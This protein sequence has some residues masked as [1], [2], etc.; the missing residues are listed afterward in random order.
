M[1]GYDEAAKNTAGP[2]RRLLQRLLPIAFYGGLLLLLALILSKNLSQLGP[3][4]VMTAIAYDSESY[5]FAIGLA[6]WIQWGC[7]KLH[8]RTRWSAAAALSLLFAGLTVFTLTADL[9]GSVKTLNE[10]F[11]ALAVLVP[12]VTLPRPLGAWPVAGSLLLAILIGVAVGV[13]PGS[14]VVALAEGMTIL[15]LTPWAFDVLDREVLDPRANVSN[16]SRLVLYCVL[17]LVPMF[18]VA[19]GVERRT[20]GGFINDVLHYLGRSQ[21]SF[22]G[23]L[24]VMVYLA[25][26]RAVQRSSDGARIPAERRALVPGIGRPEHHAER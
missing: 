5:V 14:L 18:V 21:E 23:V 20:Q 1:T 12:F 13:W 16:W 10:A 17:F 19:L 7:W 6:A 8:G 11:F 25:A 2:R 3:E 9:P 22:V 15:A 4:R 26:V 24:L